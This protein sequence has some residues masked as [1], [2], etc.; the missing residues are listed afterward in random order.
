MN[1]YSFISMEYFNSVAE[2]YKG[3]E[4]NHAIG[5]AGILGNLRNFGVVKTSLGKNFHSGF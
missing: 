1:E 4:T 2:L 3:K 5:D